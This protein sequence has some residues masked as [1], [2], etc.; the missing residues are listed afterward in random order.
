VGNIV[1]RKRVCLAVHAISELRNLGI[2]AQL[3]I[4]GA[5]M[6]SNEVQQL[7]SLINGQPWAEY[8]GYH[9]TPFEVIRDSHFVILTS[10]H[11]GEALPRCALE[12]QSLGVPV[13]STKC[14]S[15]GDIVL[16]G[17]TGVIVD[18]DN[19]FVIA[20]EFYKICCDSNKYSAMSNASAL[21]I[22]E[23]FDAKVVSSAMLNIY[24]GL[25]G[26]GK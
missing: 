20:N 5:P 22:S 8:I 3:K 15:I 12:A 2:N 1:P 19:P 24:S 10:T 7:M 23:R 21:H 16:N 14:G 26:G 18:G 11:D 17:V 25:S 13:I 9:H 4:I 6:D